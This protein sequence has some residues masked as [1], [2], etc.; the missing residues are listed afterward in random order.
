MCPFVGVD[1]N[2]VGLG[3]MG[4]CRLEARDM[5]ALNEPDPRYMTL[6]SARNFCNPTDKPINSH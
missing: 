4:A 5:Y 6:K 1:F 3:T 2:M